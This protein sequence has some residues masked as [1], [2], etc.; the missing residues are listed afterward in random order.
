MV[1]LGPKRR[2]E[3]NVSNGF[4]EFFSVSS[5]ISRLVRSLFDVL[6]F[7]LSL[8]LSSF[9]AH[10]GCTFLVLLHPRLINTIECGLVS[11]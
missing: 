10:K 6:S 7:L 3:L 11:P 1:P 5:P 9:L 8:P 2:E 4:C